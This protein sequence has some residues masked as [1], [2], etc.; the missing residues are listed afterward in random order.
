MQEQA[1]AQ[2]TGKK[3]E[4]ERSKDSSN[5]SSETTNFAR[6][7]RLLM[8]VG[9]EVLMTTFKEN[10]RKAEGV[11]W[12]EACGP[13]FLD[14]K[15]PDDVS[16][17]KLGKHLIDC[18]R[19]GKC[20]E[21]D[22]TLLS[23]LLVFKP[24]YVAGNAVGKKAVEALR[25]ERNILAHSADLLARQSLTEAQFEHK[26]ETVSAALKV[27]IDLLPG[28]HQ[29]VWRSKIDS[30]AQE[31]MGKSALEPLFER[32]QEDMR[33][34]HDVAEDARE[35]AEEAMKIAG[36]AARMSQLDAAVDAKLQ[37]FL[38]KQ[39]HVDPDRLPREVVFGNQKRYRLLRQ[40]GKG[41]MGTVFEAKLIAA[42]SDGSKLALKICESDASGRAER[43][44]EILKRLSELNHENIVKFYDSTLDGSHL[45]IIME[46]IMGQSLDDWLEHRYSDGNP[47]V[48]F[49]ETQPIVKQLVH[50]MSAIHALDI[51]HR[52]LKPGNLVFDEV[53]GKLVIVDFGLSKQHNT[54]TTVTGVGSQL[55][56]LLYMSPEQY[57]GDIKEISCSS[58][59]WAIG[60]VWHEMLTNY[61]P[62]EPAA[63]LANAD[64][65][66]SSKRRTLSK[67]EEHKM[68]TRVLQTGARKLPLLDARDVPPPINGIIA[69]CLCVEKKDRYEDAQH[70]FREIED[71]YQQLEAKGSDMESAGSVKP[72]KTW[73]A[74]EVAQL[75]RA[76]GSAF[77]D[78]ADEIEANGI[79]GQYFAA[80]LAN[81]D[82]DLTTSIQEGGL[83]FS[84]L[85][86]NRVRTKIQELS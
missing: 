9:R 56:T 49:A 47:G 73:S 18:I 76:I 55:G 50:G 43:E 75:V 31:E 46:L 54:N 77:A 71:V 63:T 5:V 51:A 22:I 11:Q 29:A 66:S 34:I 81:N 78:K 41:G 42:D 38:N 20:T 37:S 45:V 44:A 60:V 32:V 84:R 68:L 79:D 64:S 36:G 70:L 8:D 39:G 61:T 80:M 14:A 30:I 24:G 10:Y 17:R 16:K 67:M 1:S 69:R 62:F 21:W 23:S 28:D 2:E 86:L 6:Y 58:D 3:L 83:G 13:G 7:C 33:R 48:T 85:Q 40:V 72:F 65:S 25:E 57:D 74:S 27:L 19:S 52:D 82:D 53:T 15:F 26:W 12:E 4:K 59:V 35:R